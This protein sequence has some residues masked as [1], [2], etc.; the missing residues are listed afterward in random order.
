MRKKTVEVRQM[1]D[2]DK[3]VRRHCAQSEEG[4][5]RPKEMNL[6]TVQKT[7][8]AH[9]VQYIDRVV[10]VPVNKEPGDAEDSG[11]CCTEC[12]SDVKATIDIHI[13]S[14]LMIAVQAQTTANLAAESDSTAC[15]FVDSD[16]RYG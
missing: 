4:L 10:D 9:Q 7:A 1:H 2:V 12:Y 5:E 13:D 14:V 11:S 8:E 3:I 16:T 6:Q 15:A